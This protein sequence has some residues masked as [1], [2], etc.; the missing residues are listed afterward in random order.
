MNNIQQLEV[1][2]KV[3]KKIEIEIKEKKKEY[4]G[5]TEFTSKPISKIFDNKILS[6]QI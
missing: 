4:L 3:L 1:L 2:N 5:T 6:L